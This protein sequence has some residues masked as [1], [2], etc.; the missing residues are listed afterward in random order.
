M[1]KSTEITDMVMQQQA[2]PEND[3]CDL[4][5]NNLNNI[6]NNQIINGSHQAA[7]E[8][9][10]AVDGELQS[11]LQSDPN[12]LIL[13]DD[14]NN[15]NDNLNNPDL[16]PETDVDAIEDEDDDFQYH[17]GSA[18]AVGEKEMRQMEFK[19]TDD[20]TDHI[21]LSFGSEVINA[22]AD[23]AA[24]LGNA[25]ES[26]I[27]EELSL[28]NPDMMMMGGGINPFA[29][30][31]FIDN[32]AQLITDNKQMEEQI[33][34]MQQEY[35][36][37]I[38]YGAND[39][40]ENLERE[41]DFVTHEQAETPAANGIAFELEQELISA[42]EEVAIQQQQQQPLMSGEFGSN[43]TYFFWHNGIVFLF[44]PPFALLHCLQFANTRKK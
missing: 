24:M 26:K 13:N 3:F 37:D 30:N 35:K 4:T 28:H 5:S 29:G 7:E 38:E 34:E 27:F 40:A 6:N 33:D 43:R 16:G 14:N 44:M 41:I 17:A 12:V 10:S 15:S 39:F 25:L 1:A 19:E 32:A 22:A 18:A 31:E 36:P 20:I 8:N 9:F 23:N 2:Q 11:P 42:N 21:Q